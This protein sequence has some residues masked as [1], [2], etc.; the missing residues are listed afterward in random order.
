MEFHALTVK[1]KQSTAAYFQPNGFGNLEAVVMFMCLK[2][3]QYG[4]Y[5]QFPTS[6]KSTKMSTNIRLLFVLTEFTQCLCS[7]LC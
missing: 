5:L 6:S 2:E 7:L 4:F 1:E 3:R